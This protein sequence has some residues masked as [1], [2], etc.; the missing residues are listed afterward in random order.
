MATNTEQKVI[1]E[2]KQLMSQKLDKDYIE[3]YAIDRCDSLY[4]SEASQKTIIKMLESY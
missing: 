3:G 4:L 1:D 2:I